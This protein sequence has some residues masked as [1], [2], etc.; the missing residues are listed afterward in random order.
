MSGFRSRTSTATCLG[1]RRAASPATSQTSSPSMRIAIKNAP[2]MGPRIYASTDAEAVRWKRSVT[3]M[4]MPGRRWLRRRWVH[5]SMTSRRNLLLIT[6]RHSLI[7]IGVGLTIIVDIGLI[8]RSIGRPAA[9][10]VDIGMI[11]GESAGLLDRGLCE[12]GRCD[13]GY[14]KRG[15]QCWD[16]LGHQG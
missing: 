5:F 7:V 2:R 6:C 14:Q 8:E 4:A 3:C 12:Y 16:R 11:E 10:H 1:L 13:R 15:G 9:E